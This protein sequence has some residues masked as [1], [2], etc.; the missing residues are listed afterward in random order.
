MNR[1]TRIIKL[2]GPLLLSFISYHILGVTDLLMVGQLGTSAIAGVGVALT[3]LWFLIV[4]MEGLFNSTLI[5]LSRFFGE[6]NFATMRRY[7]KAELVLAG[8]V[9]VLLLALMVPMS[10]LIPLYT[11]DAAVQGLAREY[12]FWSFLGLPIYLLN[13][14]LTKFLLSIQ[15]TKF[16]GISANFVVAL[17]I[18][19]NWVFIFGGLGVPAMGVVGSAIAT[20]LARVVSLAVYAVYSAV[21][22]RRIFPAERVRGSRRTLLKDIL[23]IGFP[24]SMANLIEIAGWVV[25][26]GFIGRLGTAS[27]ATHEIGLKIKD[28]AFL[29]GYALGE[30]STNLVG[31]SLGKGEPKEARAYVNVALRLAV[32]VMG[33]FGLLFFFFAEWLAGLFTQDPEVIKLA[34]G[35]LRIMALYQMFD[36]ILI[37]F[38]G[39]LNGLKDIK[40]VR[41]VILVAWWVVLLPLAW[42]FA[43]VLNWGVAGAWLAFLGFAVFAGFLVAT[44]FY[45][46]IAKEEKLA[47]AGGKTAV[48]ALPPVLT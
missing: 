13:W 30:I 34:G 2:T 18:F 33:V 44:R 45:K 8:V 12:L 19:L 1:Q 26:V 24:M 35:L 47:E 14:V 15:K 10:W 32:I 7:L 6:K 28:V 25:F 40:Y 16:I 39:A 5:F 9:G 46:L 27:L 29:P 31:E 11:Q 4:P 22:A 17:N 21:Q 48:T 41:N 3:L 20:L 36:A 43:Y 38:R 23:S 37:V 42:L